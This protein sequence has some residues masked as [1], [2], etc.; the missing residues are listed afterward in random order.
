[1][2]T[3]IYYFTGTGN[4]LAAAKKI[5]ATTG[6]C[7]LVP[8]ALLQKTFGGIIP[9]AE[10]VGIVCPVYF[11]GLPVMV[12]EFAQRLDLSCT[13]YTFSLV[14]FGGSG[15]SS[16]LHQLDD[17]LR[18]HGGRGLDAGFMVKMPGN[19]VLM[20]S[21][22][23]GKRREKILA[24]ADRQLGE[25]AGA[26]SRCEKRDLPSSIHANLIHALMY[27][28]FASRVHTDDRKFSVSE[29]CTSCGTCVAVCPAD[30]IE[31]VNKKPVWKHR[32]EL[33]CG[34]I[35]LCP[36]QAIRAGA[37]TEKRQRYRNPG[38]T[39]AELKIRTGNAP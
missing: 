9:H 25:I 22:P 37:G 35:H 19:Y 3:I 29:R 1:V 10:R 20:Y 21:P 27:P 24:M 32:C 4:S 31:L 38:I 26:V 7:E 16:A 33:C 15:G 34:C 8:I 11:S 30:N 18:K 28:R 14:T 2:K 23:A 5:A 39:V 36:V 13:E 17:I 6:Q 12:D